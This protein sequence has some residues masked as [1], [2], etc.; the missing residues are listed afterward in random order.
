MQGNRVW[1]LYIA[2]NVIDYLIDA[3]QITKECILNAEE[4]THNNP[5]FIIIRF[6][7]IFSQAAINSHDH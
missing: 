5:E 1:Q 6:F 3:S 7:V 4:L 2:E